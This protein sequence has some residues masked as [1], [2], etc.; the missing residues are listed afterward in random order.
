MICI[1]QSA[2]G[3]FLMHRVHRVQYLSSEFFCRHDQEINVA[4]FKV[5][6]A[7]G[8][9]TVQIESDQTVFQEHLHSC[10]QRE[11][12]RIDIGVW[13]GMLRWRHCNGPPALTVIV[14]IGT[15]RSR[16]REQI[17]QLNQSRD[18]EGNLHASE[19]VYQ[20]R[21]GFSRD[22]CTSVHSSRVTGSL[23]TLKSDHSSRLLP[24]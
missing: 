19:E 4:G 17:G 13:G 15:H 5:N 1:W 12:Q 14:S 9:R 8:E 24:L 22:I 23:V 11:K 6:I 16:G 3:N 20:M 7:Q 18:K 21:S 2:G 10:Q